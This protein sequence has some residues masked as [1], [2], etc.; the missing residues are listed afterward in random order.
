MLRQPNSINKAPPAPSHASEAPDLLDHA[1]DYADR[2]WSIIPVVGKRSREPWR[3][4]QS[5]RASTTTLQL[6][7][8]KSGIT[9]IAAVLGS[10]S[11][12]LAV[13]DFD[14]PDAYHRWAA[15]HPSDA[16]AMP[17]VQTVR[18][19][20]VYGR[21]DADA[22]QTSRIAGPRPGVTPAVKAVDGRF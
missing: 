16:L 21:L 14:D 13:R 20:H 12:G 4:F 2:G 1:L 5:R 11:G 19:A 15:Q 8:S 6:L 7:F 3:P 9:G 18:G 10:I 17:T 22:Y